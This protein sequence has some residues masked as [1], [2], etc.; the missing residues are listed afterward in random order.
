ML[1]P[2]GICISGALLIVG[3]LYGIRTIHRKRKNHLKRQRESRQQVSPF[4][5]CFSLTILA[6]FKEFSSSQEPENCSSSQDQAML[7]ADSSALTLWTYFFVNDQSH[8]GD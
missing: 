6:S 8:D 3:A 2:V 7:L 4:K 1:A 5:A